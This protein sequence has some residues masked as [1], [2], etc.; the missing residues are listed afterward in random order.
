MT[1]HPEQQ[2]LDLGQ[3]L[4]DH[5]IY[6]K[7]L[8]SGDVTKSFFGRQFRF[9]F[10]DGFPLLTTKKVYWKWVVTE[11]LWFLRGDSNIRFLVENNVHIWDDYPFYI[12]N[13]KVK[14]G[15]E[16]VMT[17]EE[18]IAKILEDA[19]FARA[20]GEL[21]KIY[22]EAWRR[23]PTRTPGRTIDQIAW[24][25]QELRADPYARNCCL[26]AWNPEYLYSM[27]TPEDAS[28]FPICHGFS[29]YSI[30]EGKLYGQL[31]QRTGDL[32][33][34]VPFN[35]A[36]YSLLIHVFA[37]LLGVEPGGLIHTFG[38]VHLYE[39]HFDQMR[40]QISRDPRALPKV[41]IDPSLTSI[42]DLDFHHIILSDYDA[43][44]PI[45]AT[46]AIVGGMVGRESENH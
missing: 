8:G 19:A 31:Y 13:N 14:K 3:D 43:H 39:T 24:I 16:P 46:M 22:S 28:K 33:L 23:W 4:L 42:D 25:L 20:H 12:Y 40:E 41:T 9:D 34:G 32:F 5:G 30:K 35:I 7:D 29:Q 27:A 10:S 15:I 38:D 18:F 45:R 2:Y 26:T 44:P 11:L 21:P 36:S 17:K 1:L 6:N 37:H